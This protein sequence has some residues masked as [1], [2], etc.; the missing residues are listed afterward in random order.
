MN[1]TA[2]D[3]QTPLGPDIDAIHHFFNRYA[4]IAATGE[5]LPPA[6][7]VN[8]IF[9]LL[10]A[11]RVHPDAIWRLAGLTPRNRNA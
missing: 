3:I 11:E 4:L 5:P 10:S 1:T 2:T 9:T 6:L 7:N 8:D